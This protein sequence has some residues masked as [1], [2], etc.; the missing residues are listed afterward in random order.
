MTHP[1]IELHTC[2]NYKLLNSKSALT[3]DRS[4]FYT[5]DFYFYRSDLRNQTEKDWS[6]NN[7]NNK[8]KRNQNHMKK[9]LPLKG[10]VGVRLDSQVVLFGELVFVLQKANIFWKFYIS[11]TVTYCFFF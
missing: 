9:C 2:K 10:Y 8:N 4:Y 1:V 3:Q 5:K 7:V 11:Y 6:E